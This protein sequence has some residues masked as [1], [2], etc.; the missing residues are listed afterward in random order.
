M[1]RTL[2]NV[3]LLGKPVNL[4]RRSFA[5]SREPVGRGHAEKDVSPIVLT[6][7]RDSS[8]TG[9]EGG[10]ANA[11]AETLKELEVAGVLVCIDFA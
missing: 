10:P 3:A 11:I 6:F 8:V 9:V 4:T 1:E 7:L 5:G 2:I